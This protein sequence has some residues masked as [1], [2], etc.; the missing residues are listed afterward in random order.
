M[1]RVVSNCAEKSKKNFVIENLG[2]NYPEIPD[3]S[4]RRI[5]LGEL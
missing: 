1:W 3:S 4:K 5:S 2:I